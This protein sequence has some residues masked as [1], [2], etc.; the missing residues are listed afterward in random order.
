[1]VPL[2]VWAPLVIVIQPGVPNVDHEHPA[3]VVTEMVPVL[4]DAEAAIVGGVTVNVHEFTTCET[5]RVAPA[6]V[7]VPLRSE[8]P[9]FGATVTV[10]LPLPVPVAPAETVSHVALLVAFQVQP[11]PTVTATGIDS[12]A[13]G[14]LRADGESDPVHVGA[15]G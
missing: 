9:L 13:P 11:A 3:L 5:S 7:T 14:E 10:T 6:I 4:P 1:M 8:V 15:P 12:P 2:P